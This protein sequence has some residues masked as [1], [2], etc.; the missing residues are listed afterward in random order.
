M[1]FR[2]AIA[3]AAVAAECPNDL[4]M[5][6]AAIALFGEDDQDFDAVQ[7]QIVELNRFS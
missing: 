2:T 7:V 3:A 1:V 5:A 6:D 4:L